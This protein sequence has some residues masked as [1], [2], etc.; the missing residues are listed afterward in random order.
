MKTI[1]VIIG[2]IGIAVITAVTIEKVSK[3]DKVWI[4][5]KNLKECMGNE[6]IINNNT[7]QCQKGYFK[8]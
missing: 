4:P 2:L 7:V 1:Y 5:G 6:K 3:D 8:E